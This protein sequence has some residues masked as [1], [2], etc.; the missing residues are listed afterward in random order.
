[1]A[2]K[3]YGVEAA[4]ALGVPY[5]VEETLTNLTFDPVIREWQVGS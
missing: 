4:E 2:V 3:R 5:A 1:M